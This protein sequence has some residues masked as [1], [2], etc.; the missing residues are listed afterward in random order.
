MT[1][2]MASSFSAAGAR[3]GPALP[4]LPLGEVTGGRDE[5]AEQSYD[6]LGAVDVSGVQETPELRGPAPGDLAD[7]FP[8]RLG[9]RQPRHPPVERPVLAVQQF[10]A[11]QPVA[12]PGDRRR[13]HRQ[14]PGQVDRALRP[15]RGQHHHGPVL[16]Q[17]EVYIERAEAAGGDSDQ[18]ATQRGQDVGEFI[19]AGARRGGR[20]RLEPLRGTHPEQPGQ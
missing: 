18:H 17:G 9:E 6:L 5:P 7:Q 12:D 14:L 10:A 16:G 13:M 8:A 1:F 15:P 19:P 3:L 2:R 20:C 4:P 11:D